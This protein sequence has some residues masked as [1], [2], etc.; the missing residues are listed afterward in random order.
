M[1]LQ[2]KGVVFWLCWSFWVSDLNISVTIQYAESNGQNLSQN[3]TQ[4]I[5]T[6]GP[7]HAQWHIDNKHCDYLFCSWNFK[8]T[9]SMANLSIVLVLYFIFHQIFLQNLENLPMS[10]FL[11]IFK[12]LVIYVFFKGQAGEFVMRVDRFESDKWQESNP[13]R[14]VWNTDIK[15]VSNYWD[16]P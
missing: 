2:W 15:F 12:L 5:Q 3:G 4:W 7:I 1:G 11:N 13:W 9:W 14:A 6:R 8:A 10:C 16:T